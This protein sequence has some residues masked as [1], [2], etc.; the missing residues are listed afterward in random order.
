[1]IFGL[2]MDRAERLRS[3]WGLLLVVS[4][5]L[6]LMGCATE[7]GDDDASTDTPVWDA[8]VVDGAF[9]DAA[10]SGDASVA[11]DAGMTS[12]AGP[13]VCPGETGCA[14]GEAACADL[15]CGV[16]SEGTEC[17]AD[18]PASLNEGCASQADC[19]PGL[20]CFEVAG[21]G[22]CL[23]P[24]CASEGGCGVSE[25]CTAGAI[26]IE[27]SGA[28]STGWGACVQASACDVLSGDGCYFDEGCFIVSNEGDTSC[29]PAGTA[30]VGDTCEVQTDCQAGLFCA[31]VDNQLRCVRICAMDGVPGPR[32][33]PGEGECVSYSQT[34]NGAGLCRVS[35]ISP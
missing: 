20:G 2:W 17:R 10:P 22:R 4:L 33:Q 26:L 19:G 15:T 7:A 6:A 27:A 21:E 28:Q 9:G 32:C 31:G 30:E 14:L 24:C 1:M 16:T 3:T 29:A 8:T 11:G 13:A 25:R 34:K 23:T 18:G 5:G 35:A 12:D